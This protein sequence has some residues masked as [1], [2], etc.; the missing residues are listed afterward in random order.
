[1]NDEKGS[2]GET[3][4]SGWDEA[5]VRQEMER[6]GLKEIDEKLLEIKNLIQQIVVVRSLKKGREHHIV[7]DLDAT[8]P[9]GKEVIFVHRA[10]RANEHDSENILISWT[11]DEDII[12][13]YIKKQN[14]SISRKTLPGLM[15]YRLNYLD[16][17]IDPVNFNPREA[18]GTPFI[19]WLIERKVVEGARR[20]LLALGRARY[21]SQ[22]A[23]QY[24]ESLYGYYRLLHFSG[25]TQE[26]LMSRCGISLTEDD[27]F[28][29]YQQHFLFQK[30]LR[31]EI[32]STTL[33]TTC[34]RSLGLVSL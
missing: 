23:S 14:N 34:T 22:Y 3:I 13:V 16:T 28:S 33:V 31:M 19:T 20:N 25:W 8:D 26:E 9:K 2:A 7:I 32:F 6:V 10:R 11:D 21:S 17:A 24:M 5:R 15:E 18:V 27:L 29:G 4:K 30:L 1:L 12:D